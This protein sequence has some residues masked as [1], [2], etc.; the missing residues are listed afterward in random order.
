MKKHILLTLAA[1]GLFLAACGE[2]PA[3]SSSSPTPTPSS[4]SSVAPTSSSETQASSSETPASS[5]SEAPSSSSSVEP[6]VINTVEVVIL[7]GSATCHIGDA[8]LVQAKVNGAAST[9]VTWSSSDPAKATVTATGTVTA[10]A[11]G[12]VKIIATS[13]VDTTKKGEIE[14]EVVEDLVQMKDIKA[15]LDGKT[16][17][18]RGKITAVTKGTVMLD[19]G[20][21]VVSLYYKTGSPDASYTVGKVLT[22]SGKL[23]YNNFSFGE[24]QFPMA[25]N[26]TITIETDKT[27][28]KTTIDEP[29]ELTAASIADVGTEAFRSKP[30]T[31]KA[32]AEQKDD[33]INWKLGDKYLSYKSKPD[34]MPSLVAGVEYTVIGYLM[35]WNSKAEYYPVTAVSVEGNTKPVSSFEL[36][37]TEVSVPV[38]DTSTVV[39]TVLPDDAIQNI[40]WSIEDTTVASVSK[41]VVTGLKEGTTKLIAKTEGKNAAGQQITK[42]IPVTVTAAQQAVLPMDGDFSTSTSDKVYLPYGWT[43]KN[44]YGYAGG[45]KASK[46]GCWVQSRD[47]KATDKGV[48]VAIEVAKIY[49]GAEASALAEDTVILK[50]EAFAS[51]EAEATAVSSAVVTA[52]NFTGAKT[53][54]VELHGAGIVMVRFTLE[55]RP[56]IE[57]KAHNLNIKSIKITEGDDD[58]SAAPDATSIEMDVTPFNLVEGYKKTLTAAV[59]P[60]EAVQSI[61]WTS[62]EPTVATV[63][64]TGVVEALNPG[65]TVIRAA[66]T[67]F[68][69]IYKEVTVTVTADTVDYGKETSPI[70]VEA[71]LTIVNALADNA[72]TPKKIVTTGV[73]TK[74]DS[75]TSFWIKDTA[76][77]EKLI[78]IFF[79]DLADGVAAPAIGDTIV[80]KGD[81]KKYV[82]SDKTKTTLEITGPKGDSPKILS[83]V[84]G[85]SSIQLGAHE[86]ATVSE[87]PTQGTNGQTIEFT[88]TPDSGYRIAS[89]M[90]YEKKIAAN[91]GVYSF[92]LAGPAVITVNAVEDTPIPVDQ[93]LFTLQNDADFDKT[94]PSASSDYDKYNGKHVYDDVTVT[95]AQVMKSTQYGSAAVLQIQKA[96]GVVTFTATSKSVHLSYLSSFDWNKD[97]KKNPI[98]PIK[99]SL[100][101]VDQ[102]ID[103]AAIQEAREETSYK[104]GKYPV[105][106][107]TVVVQAATAGE[108]AWSITNPGAAGTQFLEW[109]K[110]FAA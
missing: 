93:P 43:A 99:V 91:E 88:V 63:S 40:I 51:T 67:N 1:A 108:H 82:N 62:S 61:T 60:D 101:G 10:K 80:V 13:T 65:T 53:Y 52:A 46:D 76:D 15:N 54:N 78:N 30:V 64:T 41:G 18:V 110:V 9:A 20:T 33:F 100:D 45:L 38:G 34:S 104:S 19:D 7:D 17:N 8:L 16:I 87:I 26:P 28:D 66:A 90:V 47:F 70:S 73:V 92:E 44:I 103:H 39:G 35:S 31:F 57:G 105:Y 85:T 2:Q 50:V 22:V 37:K 48:D 49:E 14:I 106:R 5:S 59:K 109:M 42:E 29:E 81:G 79:F 23:Q 107:Y 6:V 56:V 12:K 4:E 55:H 98:I 75:E 83:N 89:V 71:A 21:G 58:P 96:A 84:R 11:L 102:T 97:S 74:F 95:T 86:N 68:P 36:D 25:D 3:K 69:N 32:V 77:A 27:I 24:A 72:S 94:N